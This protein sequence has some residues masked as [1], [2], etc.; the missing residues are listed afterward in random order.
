LALFDVLDSRGRV[1]VQLPAAFAQQKLNGAKISFIK[2]DVLF[3][4]GPGIVISTRSGRGV[5]LFTS[6][7]PESAS[8]LPLASSGIPEDI[9][10]TG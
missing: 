4:F 5:D 2:L 7:M 8:A 6:Q 9:A 3:E 1:N 10:D